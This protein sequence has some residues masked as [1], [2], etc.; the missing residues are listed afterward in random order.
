MKSVAAMLR[1]ALVDAR[2]LTVTELA[3]MLGIARP[4]LSS[5]LNGRSA[6]SLDLALRIE[7]VCGIDARKMLI[8][9]LDEQ[10]AARSK[11]A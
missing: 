11:K 8:A 3:P 6:L 1:T 4:S 10:L 5:V 2:G 9:Q 7:R